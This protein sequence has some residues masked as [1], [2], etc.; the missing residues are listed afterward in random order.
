VNHTPEFRNSV[1]PTGVDIPG[2]MVRYA[3]EV[4]AGDAVGA[5]KGG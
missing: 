5:G 2:E 3:L 1:G 4:F